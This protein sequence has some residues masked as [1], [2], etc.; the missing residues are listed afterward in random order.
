MMDLTVKI[1]LGVTLRPHSFLHGQIPYEFST[2]FSSLKIKKKFAVGPW[3]AG[4]K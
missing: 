4:K 2:W 1:I 3:V